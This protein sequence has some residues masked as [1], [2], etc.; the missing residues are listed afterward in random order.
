M[1][2]VICIAAVL[3]MAACDAGIDDQAE[4]DA[5]TPGAAQC[6]NAFDERC[7]ATNGCGAAGAF[8]CY[9]FAETGAVTSLCLAKDTT[10]ESDIC[11]TSAPALVPAPAM[12]GEYAGG[13]VLMPTSICE[14]YLPAVTHLTLN[15]NGTARVTDGDN[16]VYATTWSGEPN[17]FVLQALPGQLDYLG[18]NWST[19]AATHF[20]Q[21]T[22]GK[23]EATVEWRDATRSQVRCFFPTA[24]IRQ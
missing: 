10:C 24:F 6:T 17:G 12:A 9:H 5:G 4:P 22:A 11:T 8:C 13:S 1:K 14:G 2:R 23:Y 16:R 18:E 3:L 7:A 15:S 21:T 19:P 20:V